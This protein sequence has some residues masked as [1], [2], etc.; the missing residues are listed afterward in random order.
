MKGCFGLV[1]PYFWLM[2]IMPTFTAPQR[3]PV[4]AMPPPKAVTVLGVTSML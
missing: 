1:L 4:R 2:P 3:L